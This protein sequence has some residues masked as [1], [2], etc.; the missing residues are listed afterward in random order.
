M[1]KVI[2]VFAFF[3]LCGIGI[4]A[5]NYLPAQ[6]GYHPYLNC[7][8]FNCVTLSNE[9]CTCR[10]TDNNVSFCKCYTSGPGCSDN[11]CNPYSCDAVCDETGEDCPYSFTTCEGCRI[12]G[13]GQ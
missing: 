4:S 3:G 5:G 2:R 11:Y 13:G 9:G 10:P 7:V 12:P 1:D 6:D 8:V